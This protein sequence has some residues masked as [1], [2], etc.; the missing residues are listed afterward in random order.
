MLVELSINCALPSKW[1]PEVNTRIISL[2][3]YRVITIGTL[4]THT[5]T[6]IAIPGQTS[7][8]HTHVSP[9]IRYSIVLWM[10]TTLIPVRL[11]SLSLCAT[12]GVNKFSSAI[13]GETVAMISLNQVCP[14]IFYFK[15]WIISHL[16]INSLLP[17]AHN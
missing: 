3:L 12:T 11:R 13:A 4:S 2:A 10:K 16:S 8:Q 5:Y 9:W 14:C 7:R 17:R 1:H 6:M 15:A